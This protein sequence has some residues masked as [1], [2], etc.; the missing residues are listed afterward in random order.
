M[1]L[2][3]FRQYAFPSVVDQVQVFMPGTVKRTQLKKKK[4]L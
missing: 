1:V 2:K 4:S 3:P